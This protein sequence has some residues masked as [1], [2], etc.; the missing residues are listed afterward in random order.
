MSSS[1]T[2]VVDNG[3]GFVKV[4]YAGSNFPEYV[5]PSVVGRPIL[6][7]EE[8]IGNVNV[9]DIMVGD[10]AAELRSILQM[11]YPMQNGIVKNWTDM[12]HLWD[13]TFNDKLKI[14]PRD[15]KIM[16]TEP[17]MNPKA[18]REKMVETMLEEY[19]F[20]GVYVAIQAVLTLYAQ[21]L[22]TGV[23]VDSGDGVTH[24][25]PVVDGYAL[26]HITRRLDVAGRDVT[27]Y[28]I[29][30]LLLRGYAF[31]RTADFETV[32]QIKEKLCYT[33]YDLDQDQQLA[34]ETTVLVE[35]YTLPDGRVIKV[36]S[37]RF[38]APECMFQPHLIDKEQGGV[39]ELLFQCI[40]SAPVDTRSDLYKHIVLSGGSTMYPGLPS[41]LEKEVKQLYLTEVLQGDVQRF[42]NF[43]IRIEDP[44]RRKHMVFLGGAVLADIMKDKESFWITKQ[45]WE[46]QGVRALEKLGGVQNS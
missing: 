22:L 33:S 19:G 12:K 35:S 37:E 14:D 11:S 30:L 4:G 40:Q 9:R 25:V 36:G 34:N 45:E 8:H 42:R 26:P 46:E 43:K 10:E 3:T 2:I 1:K 18:N 13:Y 41:R 6:R 15:T 27:Q 16:L 32:R 29:K 17:P 5:F 44:P 20:Q 21:G 39:A 38:E 24:I 23:V 7:A 28:L 31:N